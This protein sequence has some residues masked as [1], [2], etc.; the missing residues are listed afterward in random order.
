MDKRSFIDCVP[1]QC[2]N[3]LQACQ[4]FVIPSQTLPK[5]SKLQVGILLI[6]LWLERT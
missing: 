2:T 5:R 4:A 6:K 1:L 3:L